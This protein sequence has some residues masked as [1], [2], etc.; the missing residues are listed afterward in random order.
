[1]HNKRQHSQD[2]V[3]PLY[4]VINELSNPIHASNELFVFVD[5]CVS[6]DI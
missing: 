1:M 4:F 6:H 2:E 3:L 5:A